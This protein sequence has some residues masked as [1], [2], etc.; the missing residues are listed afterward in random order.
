MSTSGIDAAATGGAASRRLKQEIGRRKVELGQEG[1]G[2]T[3]STEQCSCRKPSL[4]PVCVKTI[5]NCCE[6]QSETGL[7]KTSAVYNSIPPKVKMRSVLKQRI[8]RV[9][10]VSRIYL[11]H[12]NGI[13]AC[14]KPAASLQCSPRSPPPLAWRVSVCKVLKGISKGFRCVPCNCKPVF[15]HCGHEGISCSYRNNFLS[16][17]EMLYP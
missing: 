14:I 5:S 11:H 7:P 16:L 9:S 17:G 10:R 2:C 3:C 15:S 13:F 4:H 1:L 12:E 8:A 6:P